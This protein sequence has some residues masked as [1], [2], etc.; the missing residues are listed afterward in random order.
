[1]PNYVNALV[2]HTK[3]L[4][5]E[6]E[7]ARSVI[8]G[9]STGRVEI[10]QKM[11]VTDELAEVFKEKPVIIIQ[12]MDVKIL[13]INNLINDALREVDLVERLGVEALKFKDKEVI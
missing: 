2:Y 6:L 7:K 11:N 5:K 3:K 1:M 8:E 9:K 13:Q 10:I 12:T 4:R